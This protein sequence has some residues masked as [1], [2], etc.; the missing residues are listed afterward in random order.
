VVVG[1]ALQFYDFLTY[2]FFA[3]QIGRTFFPSHNA[4]SSLLASLAT[5]GVGFLSRPIGGLVIGVM[6][7]RVGR[8]PAMML[9][10]ALM[11]VAIIGL[12]LTPSY[13]SI[14]VIAPI[15]VIAFRLLQGFALG[16]EV[17]PS[18][19][20]LIEAAPPLKRGLYVS[21]QY[22]TQDAAVLVA[23]LVGVALANLLTPGDLDAWGWRVAFL[24]GAV[25]V[26]FGLLL[27]GGLPETLIAARAAEPQGERTALRPHVRIAILGLMLLGSG[28]IA[29]Y[30]LT[31]MTTYAGTTLHMKASLA[32]GATVMLGLCGVICDPVGGWLSDRYGRKR[33]MLAPWVLLL[34]LVFPAF[35]MLNHFRTSA[36]LLAAT[37]L[38]TIPGS[39]SGSSVLVGITE[40]L[41]PRIRSGALATLYAVAIATFGGTTQFIVAWL[42]SVTG[43]PLAPAWY[44]AGA[45]IVGVIA[46]VAMRE[47]APR[48]VGEG[49][50]IGE[51]KPFISGE[52]SSDRVRAN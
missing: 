43:N 14:G 18:T 40:S 5:F 16:G 32:F 9:S 2:A 6:G 24:I 27:R 3:V 48:L 50:G 13:R 39:I 34:F 28:T 20:F 42:I 11:G 51:H 17:G 44:M 30:L 22:M 26:P 25:I 29:S 15:A 23:G 46:M 10:F 1:N 49:A 47:T 31:Y 36:A 52:G 37:A 7:D 8:K 38:L 45:V 19:A 4:T 33:V 41:P 12:A 21:L 35:W